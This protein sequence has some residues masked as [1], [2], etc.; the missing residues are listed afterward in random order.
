MAQNGWEYRDGSKP[1]PHAENVFYALFGQL[2]CKPLQ[3]PV[4][5][6]F[7]TYTVECWRSDCRIIGYMVQSGLLN[8]CSYHN[9]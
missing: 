3:R 2:F 1:I 6:K 8:S 5:S 7:Y 9:F 4:P